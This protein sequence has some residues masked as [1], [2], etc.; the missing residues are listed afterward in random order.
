MVVDS[1][2]GNV[3]FTNSQANTVSVISGSTDS[4]GATIA[5]GSDLFGIGLDAISGA[6][7]VANRQNHDLT[8]ITDSQALA[9]LRHQPPTAVGHEEQE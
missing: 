5:V 9:T 4:V 1:A 8:V 2:T 7:S 3:F 6:V